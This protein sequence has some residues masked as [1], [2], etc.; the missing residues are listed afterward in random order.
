MHNRLPALTF[1]GEQAYGFSYLLPTYLFIFA[2]SSVFVRT[3]MLLSL[4]GLTLNA[5]PLPFHEGQMHYLR[6]VPSYALLWKMVRGLFSIL[7]CLLPAHSLW[8]L[9]GFHHP[10]FDILY[11]EH[12]F[13]VNSPCCSRDGWRRMPAAPGNVPYLQG[14]DISLQYIRSA[15][16]FLLVLS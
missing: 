15:P 6:L 11:L 16:R 13:L 10:A 2:S 1:S 5:H 3:G 9:R 14:G 4:A 8:L 7:V 12:L